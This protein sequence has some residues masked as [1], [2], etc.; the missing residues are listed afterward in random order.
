MEGAIWLPAAFEA[1][2]HYSFMY[3]RSCSIH[4]IALAVYVR[5]MYVRVFE[6]GIISKDG[7]WLQYML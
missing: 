3:T 6:Y 1:K 5:S 7:F 2:F 4:A